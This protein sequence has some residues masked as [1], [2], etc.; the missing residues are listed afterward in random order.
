MVSSEAQS[1]RTASRNCADS[2]TGVDWGADSNGGVTFHFVGGASYPRFSR[3]ADADDREGM[4]RRRIGPI[5]RAV[6]SR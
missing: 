6:R 5:N 3:V 2:S 4:A 1:V